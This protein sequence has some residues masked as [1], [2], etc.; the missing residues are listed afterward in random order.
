MAGI[1]FVRLGHSVTILER[2]P[3]SVLQDQGAG[4]ALYSIIAQI[5]EAF[6]KLGTSGSP[7]ADFLEQYDRTKT[8][9]LGV[10][11]G[12]VLNRDGSIKMAIKVV[13]AKIT[14]WDLLYNTLRANYDGGF[15]EGYIG[16]AER[17]GGDGIAKY[18]TGA[19]VIDLQEVGEMV[20]VVYED[21]DGTGSLEADIVVGADGPSS[22]VRTL[23]LPKVERKY[24]GYVIWR[25][26]VKESLLTEE[27]RRFLGNKVRF[28]LKT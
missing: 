28:S 10:D 7:I 2:T 26:T 24:A 1:I 21:K 9:T 14:S 17:M 5:R 13:D 3:A 12:Q 27:T 8:P 18:L 25:G 22:T 16:A 20:K 19:G 11:G 6:M 4:I 15:D 23:L